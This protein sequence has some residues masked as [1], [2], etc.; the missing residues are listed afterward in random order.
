MTARQEAGSPSP[1]TGAR[2]A[3]GPLW[4][5]VVAALAHMP[6]ARYD[7]SVRGERVGLVLGVCVAGLCIV[8]PATAAASGWAIQ[9]TPNPT[10]A[11]SSE[12]E[13]VSCASA[14][15]CTAVG[16]YRRDGGKVVGLAERW[17]GKR[18]T[19]EPTPNPTGATSSSLTGVSCTAARGCTA[20][21]SYENAIGKHAALA[22]RWSGKKW[23]IEPAPNP[24]GVA[25]SF[26]Y[27]VSC[28]SARM[29]TA[30]GYYRR[31]AVKIVTLVERWNGKKWTIDGTP[32]PARAVESLL[33]GVSC[34]AASACTTVGSYE[35]GTGRSLALAE[36]WNGKKWTIERTRN[37]A[38]AKAS[39][40][41]GVS[42]T[43]ASVCAAV[44]YYRNSAGK[45]ITLSER[46]SGK[47]W[48][49]EPTPTPPGTVRSS[50]YGVSCTAAG[51]C[52]AVG[53]YRNSA[54]KQLTV[55]ERWNGNKWTIEPTPNP[56]GS[57]STCLYGASCTTTGACTAVGHYRNSSRRKL[58]LAEQHQ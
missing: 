37:P 36:R 1:G 52:T 43:R 19:I 28:T 25:W 7:R 26:L 10:G 17:N 24:A 33:Y 27:G 40:L 13:G 42:C 30:V 32:N 58:T 22:E 50:L 49:I 12:L 45:E 35:N 20:V 57:T 39:V 18:W 23:T 38:G 47:R 31:G 55:A 41:E 56:A 9:R 3:L 16:F 6:M 11:T 54:G 21:G 4:L 2:R 34:S 5:S 15:A 29:C 48:T 44:G 8:V 51:A 14:P 46:W 53:P